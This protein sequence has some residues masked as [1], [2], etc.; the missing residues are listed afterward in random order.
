[1]REV[2]HQRATRP[3]NHGWE[4]WV[5][6]E[7]RPASAANL[8]PASKFQNMKF[9]YHCNC[10]ALTIYALRNDGRAGSGNDPALERR[11]E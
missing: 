1:M 7:R 3:R 4:I 10:C 11:P 5:L 9:A 8:R 2:I 6:V